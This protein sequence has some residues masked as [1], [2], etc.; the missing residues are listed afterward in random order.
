MTADGEGVYIYI[1]IHI[2]IASH[3]TQARGL[4]VRM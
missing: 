4:E 1:I 3:F 2:F